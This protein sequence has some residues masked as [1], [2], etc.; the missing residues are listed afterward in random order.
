MFS[1]ISMILIV[2]SSI[3]LLVFIHELGHFWVARWY[4]IGVKKFS[5]GLGP[6]LISYTSHKTGTKWCLSAI[7]LGGYVRFYQQTEDVPL[8]QQSFESASALAR[9]AVAA[10]GPLFNLLFALC[11]IHL[12]H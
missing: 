3:L 2:A 10:A 12:Q 6:H 8:G 5:I 4:K 7:P 9:L 1:I 11:V